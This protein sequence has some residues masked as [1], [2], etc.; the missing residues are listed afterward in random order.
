MTRNILFQCLLSIFNLLSLLDNRICFEILS[1]TMRKCDLLFECGISSFEY[2]K[3]CVYN[4]VY[5][6]DKVNY[7]ASKYIP[8]PKMYKI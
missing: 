8:S 2:R 4:N 1:L 7:K 5:M 3:L 6:N